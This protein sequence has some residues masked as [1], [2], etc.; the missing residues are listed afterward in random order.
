EG[1]V[2]NETVQGWAQSRFIRVLGDPTQGRIDRGDASRF[3]T[4][5]FQQMVNNRFFMPAL[6]TT[7][8][9]VV[10]IIPLQFILAIVMAL[11]VQADTK[12]SG[13]FLY[14]FTI[15]LGVSDLAVG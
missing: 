4:R 12:A 10:I 11:V 13:I 3:T 15:A 1:E 8:L 14:I 2:N 6:R 7:L 9:L 5:Y